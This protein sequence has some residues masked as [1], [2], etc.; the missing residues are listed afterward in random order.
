MFC[1]D[2]NCRLSIAAAILIPLILLLQACTSSVLPSETPAPTEAEATDT[3]PPLPDTPLP[4]VT[5]AA[6][7]ADTETPGSEALEAILIAQPGPGSQVSSPVTV[8]GQ[9]RP[10]FEQTLVV[11]VYGPDGQVLAQQPTTLDAPAGQAGNFEAQVAFEVSADQPGRIVVY[12][13]SARDG[14]ILH[15]ASVEVQL[16]A[17]SSEVS[18]AE[19]HFES[20]AI[21]QPAINAEVSGGTL[22][23][24]GT[25]DYYFESTLELA[26]CGQGGSGAADEL[27][28]SEDN[29]LALGHATIDAADVGQPG[30]FSGELSYAVTEPVQA[31]VVVYARSPRDGGLLHV[32]SIP[33][34]L[35]P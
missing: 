11:A 6:P 21:G 26:L 24:S 10:T 23:V 15:L 28:G 5:E 1:I 35:Q 12:E 19:F 9:S 4:T 8:V 3:Q 16:S 17:T 14:G 32:N 18:D 34:L 7:T 27:C 30:P 20:I 25:S 33:V 2:K 31:R 29:I 22:T 13:T